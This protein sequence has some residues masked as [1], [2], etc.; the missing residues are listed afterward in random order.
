METHDSSPSFDGWLI[1]RLRAEP[2]TSRLGE[3]LLDDPT[4]A[5]RIEE[6][7]A[8][9]LELQAQLPAAPPR[10]EGYVAFRPARDGWAIAEI[11]GRHP[12]PGEPLLL[13][14]RRYR[15]DRI[16]RS[17]FPRDA[18]PCVYLAAD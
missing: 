3:L 1:R 13:D 8:L 10:A 17:P 12:A 11:D 5:A 14:G 9:V 7:E 4:A 15:V 2:R 18:R 16:G 6:L